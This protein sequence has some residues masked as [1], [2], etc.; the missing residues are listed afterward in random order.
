MKEQEIKFE[1][2]KDEIKKLNKW[3]KSI[4]KE[5]GIYGGYEY[6]FDTSSGIGTV[7]KVYS[8]IAHKIL[9]LTDYSKW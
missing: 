6:R 9:N 7:I 3:K 5:Y 4:K 2:D 1:L 8:Y